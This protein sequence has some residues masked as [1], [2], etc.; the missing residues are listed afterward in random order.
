MKKIMALAIVAAV[1]ATGAA[2]AEL[3]QVEKMATEEATVAAPQVVVITPELVAKKKAELN[4]TTWNISLS[5][6]GGKGKAEADVITF[7]DDK[8]ISANLEKQGFAA[9]SFSVRMQD[10]GTV[11]W[12]TMQI[13]ETAGAAFWRGDLNN[14]IMRGVL[15]K[16]DKRNN[17]KDFNYV[18]VAK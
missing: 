4:G 9:S 14:G 15:S 16:R 8:V 18:S 1:L 7:A 3:G 11:T 2:Y 17:V 12:E 5:P 6:M 10:D 13:S